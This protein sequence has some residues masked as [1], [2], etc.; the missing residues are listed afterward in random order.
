MA[1]PSSNEAV[2]C[3]ENAAA[4]VKLVPALVFI[5]AVNPVAALSVA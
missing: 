5:L 2:H 4:D 3:R 1:Q